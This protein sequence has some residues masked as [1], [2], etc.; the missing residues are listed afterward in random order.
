MFIHHQP[1]PLGYGNNFPDKSIWY[2][3]KLLKENKEMLMGDFK[4][5]SLSYQL[6]KRLKHLLRT[7]DK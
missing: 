1:Y 7:M 4:I 6:M 5:F 2:L 3:S